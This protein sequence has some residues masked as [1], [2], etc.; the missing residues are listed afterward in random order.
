MGRGAGRPAGQGQLDIPWIL[1]RLGARCQS[2][3]LELWPPEQTA[4][5]ETIRLE[6]AWA[7][8]SVRTLRGWIPD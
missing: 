8:E 7:A 6:Q 4:K 2:A 1:A 5:E 3:I